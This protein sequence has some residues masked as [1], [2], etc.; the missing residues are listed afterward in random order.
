[1]AD[2]SDGVHGIMTYAH[3]YIVEHYRQLRELSEG[4]QKQSQ[5]EYDDLCLY[6]KDLLDIGLTM[7]ECAAQRPAWPIQRQGRR[8]PKHEW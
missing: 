2:D 3:E 5:R 1:M 6:W 8:N 7:E 4:L